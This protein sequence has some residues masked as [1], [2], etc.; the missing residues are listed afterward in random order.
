LVTLRCCK[1]ALNLAACEVKT[2]IETI[3][4]VGLVM[5]WAFGLPVT[6]QVFR[7]TLRCVAH[8]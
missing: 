6:L 1:E 7:S 3:F 8:R 4:L 2:M 5:A